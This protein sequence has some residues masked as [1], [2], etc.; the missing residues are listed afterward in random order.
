[1]SDYAP[2]EWNAVELDFGADA[3]AP[4]A[5]GSVELEFERDLAPP[6]PL[7]AVLYAVLGGPSGYLL[8]TPG[9]PATLYAVLG[10]PFGH[11]SG[12]Y[13][14]DLAESIG[15][16]CSGHS[17]AA[18]PLAQ[19]LASAWRTAP[20]GGIQHVAASRAAEPIESAQTST[21]RTV[22]TLGRAGSDHQRAAGRIAV[23]LSA[24]A[25]VRPTGSV[26]GGD[27]QRAAGFVAVEALAMFRVLPTGS[28]AGADRAQAAAPACLVTASGWRI[29]G[30][31][32]VPSS[33]SFRQAAFPDLGLRRAD[34]VE[35]PAGEL[36][37]YMPP[38]W[39][40]VL[41]DF[42]G[43][44]YTP[45]AWDRV[46]LA[47]VCPRRRADFYIPVRGLYVVDSSASLTRFIDGA[48]LVVSS[49]TLSLDADSSSWRCA[50]TVHGADARTLIQP[51]AAS[52]LVLEAAINGSAWRWVLE[53]AAG[54]ERIADLQI[55]LSG[56]SRSA[57]LDA[58]WSRPRDYAELGARS[59]QQLAAAELPLA[60]WS[61]LWEGADWP[62]PADVWSYRGLSPLAA[63]GRIAEAVGA[64]V[65]PSRTDQALLVR[66]RYPGAPWSL[67]ALVAAG[68]IV[69]AID[70][71]R[72]AIASTSPVLQFPG[73]AD[74][75]YLHS[76]EAGV[77][78]HVRRD[79]TAGAE[80]SDTIVDAL[81]THPDA[82][83]QRGI[84]ELA[85]TA[86][87]GSLSQIVMP[88]GPA[89]PA[90]T[91][92]DVIRY[93]LAGGGTELAVVSGVEVRVTRSG[94]ALEVWQTITLGERTGNAWQRLLDLLPTDPLLVGTV[95]E[96]AP[97]GRRRV[98]LLGGGA[99]W[100]R[101]DAGLGTQAWVRSGRIEG[102]A[103]GWSTAHEIVV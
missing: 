72:S 20:V 35:P 103:P 64:I 40:A 65:V 16:C 67:D 54:S 38:A 94:D 14:D 99:V 88:F 62:V 23:D 32:L 76:A 98:T 24:S 7:A 84:R 52:A 57:L 27:H 91:P 41:L 61:L 96:I 59:A 86:A 77:L 102:A 83:R 3:Y 44:A 93:G 97:D 89:F 28:A 34:T 5:W 49:M 21:W 92:G 17:R 68:E 78:G 81:L 4:P 53:D 66:P 58:P 25:R 51:A 12:R 42:G 50:A 73:S 19:P 82:L 79:G 9:Q 13:D 31:L 55:S 43:L 36:P 33:A 63:I 11:F 18:E 2:P 100:V 26:A 10:G 71:P 69:P 37:C 30:L 8:G 70:I 39:D 1:M 95:D 60:G 90:P 47:F 75:L 56:R 22:E 74:A 101:G 15:V 6:E 80:V 45:P 48:P 46:A 29:A 85:R 87:Q